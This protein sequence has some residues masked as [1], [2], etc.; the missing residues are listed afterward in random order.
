GE[1]VDIA[2]AH[3]AK[4]GRGHTLQPTALVHEAYMKLV[5]IDDASFE[6]RRQFY[7]L[8]ARI[9]RGLLVDHAR[10]KAADKRGGGRVFQLDTQM[11]VPG[12]AAGPVGLLD[13]GLAIEELLAIDAQLGTLAELRYLGGLEVKEIAALTETAVRT[14]ER[15]L[16]VA[17]S[18][19]RDRLDG[20]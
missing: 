15:R 2:R 7:G 8:A 13:V 5:R 12:T 3:M 10:A 4:A 9:M 16:Q 6:N 11:P 1:L 20:D 14:V 19:L 17:N 18:W